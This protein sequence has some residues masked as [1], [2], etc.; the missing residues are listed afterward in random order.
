[1]G[2]TCPQLVQ[3]DRTD[4]PLAGLVL[5][6]VSWGVRVFRGLGIT[7]FP[8]GTQNVVQLP[9]RVQING[10]QQQNDRQG[11]DPGGPSR[12]HGR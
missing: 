11:E 8:S 10:T 3:A 12:E 7:S 6:E 4:R 1:M 2:A 9:R 5:L